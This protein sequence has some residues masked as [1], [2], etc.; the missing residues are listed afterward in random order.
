[1]KANVYQNLA[2]RTA[3]TVNKNDLIV[4]G[5]MGL[6]GESGEVIDIV[7]KWQYQGHEIDRVKLAKELGDVLWYC[8]ILAEGLETDLETVMI[9]N[10]DKLKARYPEGFSAEKSIFRKEPEDQISFFDVVDEDPI[11]EDR[12]NHPCWFCGSE[13]IWGSDFSFEDYGIDGEGIVATLT[14]SGCGADVEFRSSTDE[15]Y[16]EGG[17]EDECD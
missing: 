10:I 3:S 12:A 2:L 17:S 6:C 16:D 14:C 13:L 8:A 9:N 5:A 4:N 15:N 7:K 1:M 11:V